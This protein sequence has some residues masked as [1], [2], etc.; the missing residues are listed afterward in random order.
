MIKVGEIFN[1]VNT[2]MMRQFA[3]W[4]RD[5]P[6]H[7]ERGGIR[8][9]RVVDF[10]R[11]I[12]PQ[13]Y[14]IG[15]GHIIDRDRMISK[16]SD[17]VIY[18]A[19]DGIVFPIDNYYSLFPCESV[20]A[21]IEVKSTLTASIGNEKPSGTIFDCVKGTQK[22]R[23]LNRNNDDHTLPPIISAVFSYQTTWKNKQEEQVIDWFEKIGTYVSSPLPE[24]IF[25]LK[26]SFL[27]YPLR[28]NGVESKDVP[29]VTI[30]WHA[31]S[32]FVSQL[33]R[34][35]SQAKVAVPDMWWEYEYPKLKG[36]T[37]VGKI[38]H[39]EQRKKRQKK[40]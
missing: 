39:F 32:Q 8:E 12:L 17:I 23:S 29:T 6:H 37:I 4:E 18:D 34:L 14:G 21:S 33:I 9:R 5:I 25:V 26:P 15:T 10:L 11:F 1:E 28:N 19:L 35:L 31:L 13:R 22:L 38:E 7:G 30:Q 36:D 24:L 3:G 20:F 16:Q 40:Y 27:I 2:E